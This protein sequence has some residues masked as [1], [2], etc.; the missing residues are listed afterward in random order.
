MLNHEATQH[1]LLMK[2]TKWI[3]GFFVIALLA[4]TG[5]NK[6]PPPAVPTPGIAVK[7]DLDKFQEPFASSAE[8]QKRI[9]RKVVSE[10]RYQNYDNALAEADKLASDA[11]LTEPQ[12]K[13]VADLVEQIKKISA[14]APAAP[15]Q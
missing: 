11:S 7:V 1:F 6:G 14:P 4:F 12:K 5:C 3:L 15:A 13:A 10:V 8:E 9:V 2:T